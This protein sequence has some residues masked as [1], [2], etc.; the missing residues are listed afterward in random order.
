[1]ASVHRTLVV[2]D[3]DDDDVVDV[4]WALLWAE[5][6]S[7]M[8]A[9]IVDALAAHTR[10]PVDEHL[11]SAQVDSNG[12]LAALLRNTLALGANA[13]GFSG[14]TLARD[15]GDYVLAAA[16]VLD[17]FHQSAATAPPGTLSTIEREWDMT[18]Q[19][20]ARTIA[21]MAARSRDVSSAFSATSVHDVLMRPL[22]VH[23]KRC[24]VAYSVG[25]RRQGL[26]AHHTALAHVLTVMAP[27][28]DAI[29]T[30]IS[31][32]VRAMLAGVRAARNAERNRCS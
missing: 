1:M 29:S 8:F 21:S 32:K 16:R 10:E 14:D 4:S 20:T 31:D 28:F 22:L 7:L 15:M 25:D 30:P 2:A 19:I 17:A 23:T 12:L 18:A 27:A 9:Y 11:S 26:K 24:M 6:V 3:D 5:H 13:A